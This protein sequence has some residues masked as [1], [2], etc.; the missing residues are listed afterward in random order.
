MS[1]SVRFVTMSGNVKKRSQQNPTSSAHSV[2]A[3]QV[4]VRSRRRRSSSRVK[5]GQ[6]TT[7]PRRSNEIV[8]VACADV[9]IRCV[10]SPWR[11]AKHLDDTGVMIDSVLGRTSVLFA[12]VPVSSI[13]E[14][15]SRDDVLSIEI[16]E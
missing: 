2:D 6:P 4:P 14:I 13:D 10:G 16:D 15:R 3:G 8:P 1:I 11:L 5:D 12:R 7:T 9:V